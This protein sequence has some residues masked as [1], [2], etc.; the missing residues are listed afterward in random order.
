MGLIN[1]YYP[2]LAFH[3]YKLTPTKNFV[4]RLCGYISQFFCLTNFVRLNENTI[5]TANET[6][7]DYV[8]FMKAF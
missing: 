6:T 7:T 8:K 1:Y 2:L 4:R 3:D 5:H